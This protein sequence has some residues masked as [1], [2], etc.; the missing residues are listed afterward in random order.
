MS[1]RLQGP[2]KCH[3]SDLI[4]NGE[5][6]ID[7][8]ADRFV[9]AISLVGYYKSHVLSIDRLMH[10]I[11]IA[12]KFDPSILFGENGLQ[13]DCM[14]S[15]GCLIKSGNVAFDLSEDQWSELRG[16]LSDLAEEANA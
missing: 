5:I 9:I 15:E 1:R 11:D 6:K 13:F 7:V 10:N 3:D 16:L 2:F 12:E 14:L 4:L 8:F